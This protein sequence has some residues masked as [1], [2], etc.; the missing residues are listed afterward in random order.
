M[1][2]QTSQLIRKAKLACTS[3]KEHSTFTAGASTIGNGEAQGSDVVSHHSVGHVSALH[4]ISPNSVCVSLCACDL[5][6]LCKDG[7]CSKAWTDLASE[8]C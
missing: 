7:C 1:L 8:V 5:L 4:I 6:D 3:S 2:S